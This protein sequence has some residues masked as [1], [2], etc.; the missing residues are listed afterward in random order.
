MGPSFTDPGGRRRNGV[1]QGVVGQETL[2]VY[3]VAL[4][5]R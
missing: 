5:E 4:F 3:P 1:E 2:G